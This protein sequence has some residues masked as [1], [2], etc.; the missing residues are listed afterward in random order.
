MKIAKILLGVVI[1]IVLGFFVYCLCAGLGALAYFIFHYIPWYHI[2]LGN[3]AGCIAV[4]LYM[5]TD[6]KE[7][8]E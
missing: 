3:V 8:K 7:K 4:F 5:I 2:V 1:W 6:D